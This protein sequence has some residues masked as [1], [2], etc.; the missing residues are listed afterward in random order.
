VTEWQDIATAPKDGTLILA[1]CAGERNPRWRYHCASWD[2]V[3]ED[4][5]DEESGSDC[6]IT[7]WMP[8]PAPPN[9]PAATVVAK[10]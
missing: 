5:C 3:A 4:W 8:I 6:Q 10:P 1:Y 2:H 7:H 9:A